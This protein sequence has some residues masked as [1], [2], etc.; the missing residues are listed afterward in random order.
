M[1]QKAKFDT[2]LLQAIDEALMVLGESGRKIVY[3]HVENKYL[4]KTQ[5]IPEN[6][7]LFI[8]AVKALLGVGGGTYIETLVLKKVCEKYNLEFEN[9]KNK[10]FELA[11]P[12]IRRRIAGKM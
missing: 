4:I 5:D 6:P 11:L 12:E 2:E 8:L 1:I 7:E 9:L 3:F 10:Q